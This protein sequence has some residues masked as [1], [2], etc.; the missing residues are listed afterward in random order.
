MYW[1]VSN[2]FFF[3]QIMYV[4]NVITQNRYLVFGVLLKISAYQISVNIKGAK[5]KI[6]L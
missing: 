5:L 3:Y 1:L 6:L 4:N 2:D